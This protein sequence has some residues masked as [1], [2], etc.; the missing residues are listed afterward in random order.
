MRF[1]NGAGP[2]LQL[3]LT[4]ALDI[5]SCRLDGVELSPGRAVP[6]DGDPRILHAVGGFLF[7]CGPDHIRHPEPIAGSSGRKYPLHGSM[8]ATRPE[9]IAHDR[10]ETT[11]EVIARII[12]RMA[13]GGEA[14]ILRTWR[15]D[16]ATGEVMLVDRLTNIGQQKFPPMLMYHMNIGA[17]LFDDETMLSGSM[18]DAGGMSW[19]FGEGDGHVFCVPARTEPGDEFARVVLGPIAPLGGKSLHVRF[20]TDTLSHLQ[21]WRNQASPAHVLGI[22]PVSHPWMKRGELS[23]AGLMPLLAPGEFR[24]YRLSFSFQ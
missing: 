22:E 7:T 2:D 15:M 6:D 23:E 1:H 12:V 17:H 13:Q 3:D 4:S 5:G 11:E 21:M 9:I 8:A 18:F 14:E 16:G 20:A 10:A 24:I 19:T